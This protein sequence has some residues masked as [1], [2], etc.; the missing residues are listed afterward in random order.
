MDGQ[1]KIKIKEAVVVEGRYDKNL[2]MQIID[3]QI[4]TTEGFGIFKEKEKIA[5][6]RAVAAQRGLIVLTDADG[7]GLVIRNYFSSVV[8][9]EHLTHLYIPEIIGK[10]KRKKCSSKEGLLGVEGMDAA[11]IRALFAPF[12]INEEKDCDQKESASEKATELDKARFYS[13]G[14][15]GRDNSMEKRRA[16]ARKIGIPANLSTKA[17]IGAINMLGGLSLYLEATKEK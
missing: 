2:L 9:K 17:M 8:K 6:L 5:F 1:K 11:L 10:E 16:L 4:F 13:D 15:I 12:A 14:Y 3:T 7:A